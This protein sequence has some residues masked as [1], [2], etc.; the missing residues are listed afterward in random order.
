MTL[1][2]TSPKATSLLSQ[3]GR[4]LGRLSS[5]RPILR[6]PRYV[7]IGEFSP[8]LQRDMGFLDGRGAAGPRSG[9]DARDL[10][11]RDWMR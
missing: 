5:V 7:N 2:V 8:H 3:A 9:L 1:I 11:V 10:A 4:L 6:K